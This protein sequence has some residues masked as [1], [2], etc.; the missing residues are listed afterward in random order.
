MEAKVMAV[1]DWF[2]LDWLLG[3]YVYAYLSAPTI[4]VLP[5]RGKPVQLIST[6]SS[7]R[8]SSARFRNITL[9]RDG[10]E[11][12]EWEDARRRLECTPEFQLLGV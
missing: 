6:P 3:I 11:Y 7:Y 10:P 5:N 9:T 8:F 12:G 4:F 1:E 2:T